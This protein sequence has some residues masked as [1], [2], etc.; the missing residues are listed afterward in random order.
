MRFFASFIVI[1]SI[2]HGA[3]SSTFGNLTSADSS[4]AYIIEPFA[5]ALGLGITHSYMKNNH[6]SI[7][8][9][10]ISAQYTKATS[11]YRAIYQL[12]VA[13]LKLH[14]YSN[15]LSANATNIGLFSAFDIGLS[16]DE[17]GGILLGIEGGYG[18]GVANE[19]F[20]TFDESSFLLNLDIGYVLK[21]LD[22]SDFHFSVYPYVRVEQYVFLP[23]SSRSQDDSDYGLNAIIGLKLIGDFRDMDFWLNVGVLSDFNVSGNGIGILADNTIIYDRDG[24]SNGALADFGLNV[25]N[26]GSF[27]L[28]ARFSLNYALS[29]YELNTKGAIFTQW[30]F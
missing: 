10:G 2:C 3:E 25:F 7:N 6:F 29:Y 17:N 30:Q 1:F 11:L 13:T 14:P 21:V 8:A 28:Q 12:N 24:I 9:K 26:S 22:S 20:N 27:A 4:K 23:H 19:A 18:Y 16:D 15:Q 5:N